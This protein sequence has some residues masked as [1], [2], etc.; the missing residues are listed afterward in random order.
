MPYGPIP[1]V[2]KSAEN[3]SVRA[4]NEHRAGAHCY[5]HSNIV[6]KALI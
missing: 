2:F 5:T 3:T 6:F 1:L 4:V